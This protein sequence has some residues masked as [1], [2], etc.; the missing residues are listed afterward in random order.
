MGTSNDET[1]RKH[2]VFS[3][4]QTIPTTTYGSARCNRRITEYLSDSFERNLNERRHGL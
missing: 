1:V 3:E 2:V 4:C